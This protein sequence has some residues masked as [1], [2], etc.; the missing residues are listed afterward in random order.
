M[1]NLIF[2]ILAAESHTKKTVVIR[3]AFDLIS[4]II[5]FSLFLNS[6]FDLLW[7]KSRR[8]GRSKQQRPLNTPVE[9]VKASRWSIISQSNKRKVSNDQC[10]FTLNNWILIWSNSPLDLK[11]WHW[12][13]RQSLCCS[14]TNTTWN[15]QINKKSNNLISCLHLYKHGVSRSERPP[16]KQTSLMHTWPPAGVRTVSVWSLQE[17]RCSDTAPCCSQLA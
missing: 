5:R 14:S 6:G 3:G 10:Y 1:F 13:R 7:E 17:Q 12:I 16:H 2:D 8:G 15:N 11:H 9:G 4:P